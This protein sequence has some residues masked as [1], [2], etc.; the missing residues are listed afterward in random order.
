MKIEKFIEKIENLAEKYSTY[1]LILVLLSAVST[2]YIFYHSS[3]FGNASYDDVY[4]GYR[5]AENVANGNGFVYNIGEQVEGYSSFLHIVILAAFFKIKITNIEVIASYFTI[6]CSLAVLL[7]AYLIA[8]RIHIK[9]LYILIGL[10]G[11]SISAPY[12]AWSV[13]GMDTL[14]Y[15]FISLTAIYIYLCEN[16]S[17][18]RVFTSS[19]LFSLTALTR[20]EGAFLF[21]II[22]L[23]ELWKVQK[24]NEK[25]Q[26]LIFRIGVFSVVFLPWFIW[27]IVYYNSIFPNTLLVK[28]IIPY[29]TVN[30]SAVVSF[31]VHYYGIAVIFAF[32][33]IMYMLLKREKLHLILLFWLFFVIS[34]SCFISPYSYLNRFSINILPIIFICASIGL[35]K[36]IH[37][38]RSNSSLAILIVIIFTGGIIISGLNGNFIVSKAFESFDSDQ[39]A[40]IHIGKWLYKNS[41]N[42]SSIIADNSGAI[43]Y[44]SRRK[45]I[46]Y[47]GL[48]SSELLQHIKKGN[49]PEYIIS[50]KPEYIVCDFSNKFSDPI[51]NKIYKEIINASFDNASNQKVNCTLVVTDESTKHRFYLY[52]CNWK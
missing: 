17:T 39:N 3:M 15:T 32:I 28:R 30:P 33:G 2:Q 49:R 23:I 1:F 43:G 8:Q 16:G 46:D 51:G 44:Y 40:R 4:F 14:F 37:Y 41:S 47:A 29:Y 42:D 18:I 11:L 52:K 50:L 34:L 19:L 20:Y 25:L 12:A 21:C 6:L 26:N 13:S 27:K 22:G 36:M 31:F 5:Y 9:P 24:G 48:T 10:F 7:V 45:T 38:F 35:E